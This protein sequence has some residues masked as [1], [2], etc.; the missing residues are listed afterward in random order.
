M[1]TCGIRME[2]CKTVVCMLECHMIQSKA[3][4]LELTVESDM[5]LCQKVEGLHWNPKRLEDK[6]KS[7]GEHQVSSEEYRI[8]FFFF[9]FILFKALWL[10]PA[11]SGGGLSSSVCGLC[12]SHSQTHRRHC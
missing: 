3:R 8:K 12:V 10:M 9:L 11:T 6:S 4:G 1:A 2:E 7:I 5:S